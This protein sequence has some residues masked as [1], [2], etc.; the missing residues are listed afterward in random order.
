MEPLSKAQA[1]A[2]ADVVIA[3]DAYSWSIYDDLTERFPGVDWVSLCEAGA[4]DPRPLVPRQ[5]FI[6]P[7]LPNEAS[8]VMDRNIK[9]YVAACERDLAKPSL[10]FQR[11]S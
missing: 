8:R 9:E 3:S 11:L 2:I 6:G 5:A 7:R 10:L 4:A 1:Q